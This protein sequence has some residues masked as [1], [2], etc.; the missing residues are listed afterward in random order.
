LGLEAFWFGHWQLETGNWQPVEGEVMARDEVHK[1]IGRALTDRAFREQLL[2]SPM[3]ATSGYPF[4]EQERE[5]IA[6]LQ[7]T[8][9]EE[10]SRRLAE[11]VSESETRE[12]VHD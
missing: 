4:S 12:A 1:L 10:L 3:Q 6:S 8:S 7:A 11:F 2:Q 9:L 5:L